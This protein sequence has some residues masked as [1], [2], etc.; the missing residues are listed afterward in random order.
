MSHS[1]LLCYS[2]MIINHLTSGTLA[3]MLLPLSIFL[4]ATLLPRSSRIYWI[5][6]S[7][8]IQMIILAKYISQW[9]FSLWNTSENTE[10]N[11]S[12]AINILGIDG[13]ENVAL[14]ADL[15]LLLTLFLHHSIFKVFLSSFYLFPLFIVFFSF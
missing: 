9:R 1:E 12:S 15:F 6:V 5:S 7:C 2:A 8:Y 14:V 4:W 13:K 11:S 3:S 10:T